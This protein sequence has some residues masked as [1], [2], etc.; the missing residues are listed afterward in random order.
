MASFV[1]YCQTG[2]DRMKQNRNSFTV[3]LLAVLVGFM[4]LLA[5]CGAF[6][7]QPTMDSSSP[8]QLPF[9]E[10]KPL[11]IP[12]DTVIYVHLKQP[13][14]AAG[15]EAGQDFPAV[16]AE[17]LVADNQV[18]APQG[19]EVEGKVVA[20]RESG[21]LHAAGYVRIR[22]SSISINGKQIALATNSLIAAGGNINNHSFSFLAGPN[23]FRDTGTKQASFRPEQRLAFRL[24]QP[25][26]VAAN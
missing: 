10:T 25:L 19:A 15:A 12:A 4:G 9:T 26:S 7:T 16:L 1:H 20:A 23:S 8:Q 11:V 24:T 6:S 18:V 5:G 3:M 22:L 21:H 13:L 2:P 14:N 17:P